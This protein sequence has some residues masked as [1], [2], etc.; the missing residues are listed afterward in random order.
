MSVDFDLS[1]DLLVPS[2]DAARAR[3][4]AYPG[5]KMGPD[6]E[7]ELVGV[8]WRFKEEAEVDK[9]IMREGGWIEAGVMGKAKI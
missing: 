9:R 7:V 6:G 5:A 2:R 8:W 4:A 3:A 1:I